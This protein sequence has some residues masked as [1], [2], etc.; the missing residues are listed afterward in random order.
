MFVD[1]SANVAILTYEPEKPHFEKLLQ[2][3]GETLPSPMALYETVMGVMRKLACDINAAQDAV[4]EFVRDTDAR[5][6][7][8]DY[9]V[10][11]AALIAFQRFGKGR[12]KAKLNMGDCFGYACARIHQVPMLCKGDNFIHTD[13]KIAERAP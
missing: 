12:D 7:A 9:D 6:V 5:V 8:I 2:H 3:T 10:G 1:A 11:Q 13:I 4:N